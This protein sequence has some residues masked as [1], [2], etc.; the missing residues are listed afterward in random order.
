MNDLLIF[1][2][3]RNS[4]Y[5][6]AQQARAQGLKLA[7]LARPGRGEDLAGLGVTVVEGDA[8]NAEDCLRALALTQPRQVVSLLGGKDG[9]GRRIDETGNINVIAACEHH[10]VERALLVTSFGCGD[11][12]P[13]LSAQAASLLGE[14]L[15]AKSRAEVRWQQSPL[16][17]TLLRPGGLSH[18]E[19]S[20][21]WLLHDGSRGSGATLARAD[22]ASAILAL[23]A[24][25]ATVGKVL[26]VSGC[27]IED[28]GA[29][30]AL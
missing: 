6:L 27:A 16:A 5:L 25:A 8:F 28:G 12:A 2:A 26:C 24:D 30:A 15:A 1:G 13:L 10:G 9:T 14:A 4:G 18:A 17:I 29:S 23:L 20:G 22:L 19:G 21:R 3:S 11:L 7:A